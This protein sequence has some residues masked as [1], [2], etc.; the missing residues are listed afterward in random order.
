M[1]NPDLTSHRVSMRDIAAR[2]G[3]SHVTVSMA[4]RDSPR[5]SESTRLRVIKTARELGYRPDPMLSALAAYRHGRIN[6]GIRSSVAWINGWENPDDLRGFKEF[7]LYWKSAGECAEKFGYRIEEFRIDR[8]MPPQRL[9]EILQARGIRGILL[10]PH[11]PHQ[12]DW[13]DFPW[14]EYSVARFGRSVAHPP[15]HLVT[16]DHF[17]NT[18]TAVERMHERGYRRIGL[19]AKP[20]AHDPRGPHAVAGFLAARE[21]FQETMAAMPVFRYEQK[22][23]P[24]L[25]ER[26]HHWM[27]RE[28]PDALL[29][30]EDHGELLRAAGYRVPDDIPVA[31]TSVLDGGADSGIDQHSAEIGRVGFLLLN[32]LINDGARGIPKILRQILVE[33]TWVDGLSLPDLRES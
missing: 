9:H 30:T 24:A 13:R 27:K 31:V 29:S 15:S 5:V 23:T 25:A 8:Q 28:K 19:I 11:G 32:S 26:F 3:V 12:P 14:H 4:L 1:T 22:V 10:P 20:A 16:A 6:S 2:V 17:T 18:L 7:D 33:G 21:R